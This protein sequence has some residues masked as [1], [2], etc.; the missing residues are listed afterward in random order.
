[1]TFTHRQF[2]LKIWGLALGYF[3]FY[4]PYSGLTKA[5]SNGLLTSGPVPGTVLLPVSVI[6][7]VLGILGFITVNKW[8]KYA[9][10]R[11]VFGISV[12]FPR[13][14][15]FLSG[16][17]IA[18]IMG[19]T[20]L[21]FT[22][23]GISIVLVLVLLRGGILIVAPA[24]DAITNRRVRWFSWAA[25]LISLMA[26]TVV[27]SDASNYKMS[28]GA[29]INVAAYLIAYFFRFRLMTKF[30]KSDE[31]NTTLR[32]FVEEQMIASPLLLAALGM[33]AAIGTG[34]EMMG[35]RLGFT[36]FLGS[37]AAVFAMLV[38]LCYAGLCICTTF[39]FLDCR[40]NTFC[41]SM[42][43]GSSMLAGLTATGALTFFFNQS[44]PSA[45]Q[46]VSAGLIVVALLFL[47]PL[48]HF[49][50]T[51]N[52]FSNS[53]ASLYRM[54][55]DFASGSGKRVP[56]EDASLQPVPA[57][58]ISVRRHGTTDQEN[59]DKLRQLFLFV[60]SGNTCRSPMA[61]AIG[62]AEIAARL[63]IPFDTLD[64]A[65]AQA[66]SAGVSAR[67][68][69]PM[70]PEAQQVLRSMNVPVLPH[71]ARNLTVELAHQV[72]IIFCMTRAHQEA[73]IDMIPS[74]AGK[75]HCLDPEADIEDPI[76]SGLEAYLKCASH[77]HRLI[78]WRLDEAQ[79][80]A[81]L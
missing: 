79:L 74:V 11:T 8:W 81:S 70:T 27:L 53:L 37:K 44:A 31:K 13:R 46:I 60:C 32:Y 25:M 59:F 68:G 45:A 80:N 30:A 16:V 41:V 62:N 64:K 57:E 18:T 35:F 19:T 9:G 55:S 36:A 63:R 52:K 1:M 54:L 34:N 71:A 61:A 28:L 26:V 3:I 43:C 69:A 73:V 65:R 66:F 21:A 49:Q 67:T 15:T 42:H 75:T 2:K 76:G 23:Q 39:I 6:A 7:T 24:V 47:S 56:F 20:T 12:P 4:T 33:M 10:H 5:L 58:N 22:F 50:R 29:I 72:E 77:I 14:L 40:E 48:H 38:G 51:L 17:C 78:S